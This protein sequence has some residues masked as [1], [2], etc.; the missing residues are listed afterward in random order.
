[1]KIPIA[2]F[3]F[4]FA[5]SSG[6]GGQ[7][8]NKVNTKVTLSWDYRKS[9]SISE[10]VKKRFEKKFTTAITIDGLVKIISQRFRNQPRNIAD[11]TEKLHE[12]LLKVVKPPKKRVG[13]KPTRGSIERRIGKKK[14]KAEIKKGR[15][16]VS[17]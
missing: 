16:K 17:F 3:E 9:K 4:S 8:V 14:N 15:Q 10:A 7:N 6:A 5:R 12:M 1:M 2:E 11:C 13:T